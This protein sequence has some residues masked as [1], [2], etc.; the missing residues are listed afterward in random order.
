M[1]LEL[2]EFLGFSLLLELILDSTAST[3]HSWGLPTPPVLQPSLEE[4]CPGDL[5]MP[6]DGP[7]ADPHRLPG[8]A[9]LDGRTPRK[10]Q[11]SAGSEQQPSWGGCLGRDAAHHRCVPWAHFTHVLPQTLIGS[12]C[13]PQ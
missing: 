11:V 3:M 7:A 13:T 6:W 12:S 9:G 8:C 4:S 5:P 2:P 10:G 1:C